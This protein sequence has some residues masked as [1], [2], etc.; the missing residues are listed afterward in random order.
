MDHW[1]IFVGVYLSLSIFFFFFS[2]F[3]FRS[4]CFGTTFFLGFNFVVILNGR[5]GILAINVNS[6]K[7]NSRDYV[8]DVDRYK[9][10]V[11]G[12]FFV[13]NIM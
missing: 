3:L 1:E 7:G 4:F 8:L 9:I 10:I 11:L 6:S 13:F 2:P 5:E 12:K